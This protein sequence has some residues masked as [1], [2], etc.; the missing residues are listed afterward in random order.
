MLPVKQVS[1]V[2]YSLTQHAGSTAAPMEFPCAS[3]SSTWD[4]VASRQV[5]A[6]DKGWP[7]V[8]FHYIFLLLL[9][10]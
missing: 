4:T 9:N 7:S 2:N 10:I 6:S 3:S 8:L 1:I 5:K